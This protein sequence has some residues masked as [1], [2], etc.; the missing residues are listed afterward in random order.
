MSEKQARQYPPAPEGYTVYVVGD[1]HGRLDLLER[2]HERIDADKAR[3]RPQQT[4][5]IYLGDYID[6]GPDSAG[7]V[8]RLVSRAQGAETLFLRGNH[9]QILLDFIGG[10]DCLEQWR[11]LGAAATMLSY[12]VPPALLKRSAPTE[13]VRQGFIEKLPEVHRTFYE[14]TG[15]YVCVGSYLAVHAGIR[16]GVKLV[17][18]ATAD[19]LTIRQDFLDYEGAFE[20]IVV[21]GH[22]PVMEPD[23][24]RNRI[25]LDTGAF[26]T[27]RLTCLR[28]GEDGARV[29]A[30]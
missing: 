9:E 20:F 18:Q 23:F 2:L 5:E 25:N 3:T 26:A 14:N 24:R 27:N 7:V 11:V 29:L 13:A 15:S 30:A 21:H 19:L 1:I 28:I 8:S 10:A 6:R 12:G 17:D 22:T 4:V 16:P